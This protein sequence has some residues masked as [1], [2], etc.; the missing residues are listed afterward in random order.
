MMAI[1]AVLT[2]VADAAKGVVRDRH[3]CVLM[4]LDVKNAFNSAPWEQIDP[5][6]AG[7]GLS[8]YVRRILRSYLTDR[9]ILVS[10][11]TAGLNQE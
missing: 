9:A 10:L 11:D 2:R 4:T 8:L 1:E 6:V 3:L 7:I 5:A